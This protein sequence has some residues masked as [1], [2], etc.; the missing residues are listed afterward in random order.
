MYLFTSFIIKNPET[1]ITFAK[2]DSLIDILNGQYEIYF[3]YHRDIISLL[4]Q[5]MM[6]FTLNPD[7]VNKDLI[8]NEMKL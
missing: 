3:Q 2:I 4:F 1:V 5:R 6:Q 8:N 7:L